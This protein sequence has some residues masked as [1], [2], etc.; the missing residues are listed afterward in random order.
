MAEK[1]LLAVRSE[2]ALQV[3]GDK[4]QQNGHRQRIRWRCLCHLRRPIVVPPDGS[5]AYGGGGGEFGSPCTGW[6]GTFGGA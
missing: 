2:D 6:S 1:R 3:P 5:G 4:P